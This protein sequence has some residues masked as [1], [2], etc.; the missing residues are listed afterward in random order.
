MAFGARHE[1]GSAFRVVTLQL[2]V[3]RCNYGKLFFNDGWYSELVIIVFNVIN[4]W[5]TAILSS[6]SVTTHFTF[7]ECSGAKGKYVIVP[8]YTHTY[9]HVLRLN[10]DI[11]W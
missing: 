11:F 5:V 3:L 2:N 1:V 6:G 8:R 4:I 10:L 7:T 9:T